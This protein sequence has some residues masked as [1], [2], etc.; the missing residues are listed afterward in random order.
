MRSGATVILYTYNDQVESGQRK[1][2]RKNFQLWHLSLWCMIFR[3]R[4]VFPSLDKYLVIVHVYDE[5]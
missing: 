5:V 3:D 2:E 1:K 4:I